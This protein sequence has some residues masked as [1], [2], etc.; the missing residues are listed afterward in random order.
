MREGA[1]PPP[2]EPGGPVEVRFRVVG[3]EATPSE[4][5]PNL[6][7]DPGFH[8]TSAFGRVCYVKS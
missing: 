3:I 8:M 6:D 1:V 4:F 2:G 5:P 7:V